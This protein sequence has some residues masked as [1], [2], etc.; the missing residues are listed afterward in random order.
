MSENE[1]TT[2][3]EHLQW[4][5]DRALLELAYEPDVRKACSNALAS[6]GS[7]LRKHSATENHAGIT[8]G[9]MMLMANQPEAQDKE[10][11]RKFILGFR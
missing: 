2:R 9:M 10:A 6:M 3:A 8:L 5:K 11:M 7:D 1:S 4:C